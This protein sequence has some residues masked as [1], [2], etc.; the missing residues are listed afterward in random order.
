MIID[1]FST[2]IYQVNLQLDNKKLSDLAYYIEKNYSGNI[3]SNLGG[4]QSQLIND[5]DD[6]EFLNL[7]DSLK[8]HVKEYHKVF[9]F[10]ES[11]EQK[12][13]RIWFNINRYKDTNMPHTHNNSI[14]TGVYYVKTE[15]NC[16]DI[17][18]KHPCSIFELTWNDYDW[19]TVNR[20]YRKSFTENNSP[21]YKFAPKEG[22]LYLFPAWIS[23]MVESNL[24]NKD[25][26]SISFDTI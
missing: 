16:G 23:H 11:I 3:E 2:P 15:E 5:C 7:S 1:L 6:K 19:N 4:Y 10:D 22:E 25:R 12:I 18:F 21:V 17:S 20:I 13:H 26:I 14:F 8:Y 9:N 24:S